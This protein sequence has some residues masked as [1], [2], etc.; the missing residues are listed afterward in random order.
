[1]TTHVSRNDGTA[2]PLWV[3]LLTLCLVLGL[4]QGAA[5]AADEP[6]QTGAIAARVDGVPIPVAEIEA[7]LAEAL[8]VA[9]VEDERAVA[10]SSKIFAATLERAIDR[11]LVAARLERDERLRPT[12]EDL[13]AA[14]RNLAASLAARGSS[15]EDFQA[16]RGWSADELR[17]YLA[18]RVIWSRYLQA[19]MTDA[20]L[21]QYFDEHRADFDGTLVRVSH[22]LLRVPEKESDGQVAAAE[23]KARGIRDQVVAGK[24]SFADAVRRFSESPSR[25]QE[26]DQGFLPRRGVMVESFSRAAFALKPGETSPPVVTPFGVH[27]IH[28]TDIKPGRGTWSDAR[29]ELQ[30]AWGEARFAELAKRERAT[31]K[32]EY[33]NRRPAR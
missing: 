17:R 30:Q 4:W 26:G 10:Q 33:V 9:T 28:C 5:G 29:D 16:A 21:E 11:R 27:L 6:S 24:L 20:T 25:A 19:E 1:M 3:D 22:L 13:A 23:S 8:G 31:A 12:D 15:L 18:W 32:I 14:E 7:L 2:R